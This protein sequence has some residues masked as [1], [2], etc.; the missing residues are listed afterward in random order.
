MF[1]LGATSWRC[2]DITPQQVLVLPAPGE[3]GKIAFWHGDSVGRPYEVGAAVGALVRELRGGDEDA[4]LER[5][6]A[7][8]GL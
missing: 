5:L 1:I 3:P 7:R 6:R 8:A 2:V 4:A